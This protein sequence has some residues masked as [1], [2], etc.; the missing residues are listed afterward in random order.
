MCVDLL[1]YDDV[2]ISMLV[3]DTV[4]VTMTV[5][6]TVTM[7]VRDTLTMVVTNTTTLCL[8]VSVVVIGCVYIYI[9]GRKD[10]ARKG[11]NILLSVGVG[12]PRGLEPPSRCWRI[13]GVVASFM[14]EPI[15]RIYS[16]LPVGAREFGIWYFL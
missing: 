9:S 14:L 5:I 12:E 2:S 10:G 1:V 3:I 16:L 7:T 11:G 13:Q 4:T 8:S 6:D 15:N